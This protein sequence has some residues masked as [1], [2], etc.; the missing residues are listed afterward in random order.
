MDREK[1]IWRT[2]PEFG[3]IQGSDFGRVR[4]VERYVKVKNGK[5]LIKGRILKPQRDK[6]G[7]MY[8]C[9]SADGKQVTKKVHRIIAG[10]FLDNPDD[11][12]E[13][14]HKNA[15]RT[16][17]RVEN[18]EW[19]TRQDNIAYRDKLGHTAR[20]NKPKKPVIAVNLKTLEVLRF[21]SQHEAA[22]RLGAYQPAIKDVTKG[23]YKQHHNFWFTNADNNSVE[24]TRTKFG[25]YVAEKVAK[26]MEVQ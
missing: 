5:R 15:V 9:F 1:E 22:R 17:N 8:V 14:N 6:S 16:D 18:L 25:N 13:V 10:C 3:F 7:Y 2:Y 26:I 11:L 20:H 19:V 24:N 4:T 23:R 12:P 21:P